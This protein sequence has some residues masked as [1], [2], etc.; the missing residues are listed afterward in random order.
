MGVIALLMAILLP[1]LRAAHRQATA[2]TCKAQMRELGHAL[3][4]VFSE[5]GY[6]PIWDDLG[7]PFRYTWIDVLLQ[8][9]ELLNRRIGYCP[10]D[11]RPGFL[12]SARGYRYRVIYPGR[13]D[14]YGVDYSYGIG[15]PLASGGWNW[16]PGFGDNLRRVFEEH[17]RYPANRVLAADA[18]WSMVYNLSGEVLRGRDWSWPTQF[19]NT[20]DWRHRG[21]S[22]NVLYQDGHVERLVYNLA[23]DEPVNTAKSFLW[24]PN[25]SVYVN[26]NTY[27]NGNFYPNTPPVNLLT[28]ESNGLFPPQLVPGWYTHNMSWT[29]SK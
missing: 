17:D 5:F 9:G 12:N 7:S 10:D 29:I 3:T 23:G 25:E 8:Q 13:T 20:V 28:G 21:A 15:V 1:P 22:A 24:H 2:T 26:P 6:Y 27:Y 16:R 4:N 11:P 19:D 14:A 18:G